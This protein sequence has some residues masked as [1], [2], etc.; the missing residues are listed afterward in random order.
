MLISMNMEPE[1]KA[2]RV[3]GSGR[4]IIPAHLKGKFDVETGDYMDLFSANVDGKWYL[5]ATKHIDE[6]EEQ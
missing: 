2:Y 1:R 4:V 3:D 5:I 6:D